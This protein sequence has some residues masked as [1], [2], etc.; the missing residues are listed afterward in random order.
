MRP[1]RFLT[2]A[3][4]TKL[5]RWIESILLDYEQVNTLLVAGRDHALTICE[6][7]GHR[8]FSHHMAPGSRNL[9]SLC[10][11]ESAW[12]AQDCHVGLGFG[13]KRIKALV[14]LDCKCC[15][16]FRERRAVWVAYRDQFGT[17]GMRLESI[18]MS[19]GDSPTTHHC[20]AHFSILNL[21]WRTI[22]HDLLPLR[23]TSVRLDACD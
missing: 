22:F 8:L 6:S 5:Q 13:Q 15:G 2:R 1:K 9:N 11:M 14:P 12:R 10:R 20:K 3:R 16:S 4:L 18:E 7:C 17:L 19:L 21:V 23:I